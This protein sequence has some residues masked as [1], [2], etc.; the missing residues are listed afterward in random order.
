MDLKLHKELESVYQGP[1]F[2][3]FLDMRKA[4]DN[5]DCERI[6]QMMAGDL[7]YGVSWRNFGHARRYLLAKTDTISHSYEQ[8]EG[9]HGGNGFTKA[10][11]YGIGKRG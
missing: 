1:L 8:S 9:P 5:L 10:L 6:P 11:K 3:V 7:K 4:Y 2:L